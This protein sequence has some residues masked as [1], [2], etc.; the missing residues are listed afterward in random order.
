[1]KLNGVFWIMVVC[2]RIIVCCVSGL[3]E[4]EQI[5]V[6]G[7]L[8]SDLYSGLISG[9]LIVRLFVYVWLICQVFILSYGDSNIMDDGIG[10][11]WFIMYWVVV[12]V[13]LLFVEFLIMLM[14]EILCCVI[15]VEMSLVIVGIIVL[16]VFFFCING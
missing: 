16:V 1:M 6:G 14:L 9:L 8:F 5:Y 4:F 12:S 10:L 2:L 7:R 15:C 11:F 3:S 13:R